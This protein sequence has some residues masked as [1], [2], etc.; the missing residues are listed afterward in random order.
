M[1]NTIIAAITVS[2]ALTLIVMG[3]GAKDN[4]LVEM[5]SELVQNQ[6]NAQICVYN[7]VFEAYGK[8][9]NYTFIDIVG[10]V[11]IIYAIYLLFGIENFYMSSREVAET[12]TIFAKMEL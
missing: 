4:K 3:C 10:V 7:D 1:D 12:D 11:M 9:S 2:S 8:K 5:E 6:G